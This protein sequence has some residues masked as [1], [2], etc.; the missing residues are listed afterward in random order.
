MKN[1]ALT[2]TTIMMEL[3]ML[4]KFSNVSLILKTKLDLKNITDV[5]IFLVTVLSDVLMLGL[6]MTWSMKSNY[7]PWP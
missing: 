1:L 6:V 7:K 3:L 2:V 4:V 5:V